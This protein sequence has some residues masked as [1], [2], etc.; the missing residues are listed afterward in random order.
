MCAFVEPAFERRAIDQ[1][2]VVS[3][4]QLAGDVV[5]IGQQIHGSKAQLRIDEQR[6][7]DGLHV[8]VFSQGQCRRHAR[9]GLVHLLAQRLQRGLGLVELV[10]DAQHPEVAVRV[11]LLRAAPHLVHLGDVAV[12]ADDARSPLGGGAAVPDARGVV[13]VQRQRHR[14]A[15]G[16]EIQL[17]GFVGRCHGV[18]SLLEKSGQL[19]QEAEG[20]QSTNRNPPIPGSGRGGRMRRELSPGDSSMERQGTL[21]ARLSP[22]KAAPAAGDR[23]PACSGSTCSRQ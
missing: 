19:R 6:Q 8:E 12:Q 22:D 11:V 16:A 15:Q 17:Q 18:R 3:E 7:L 21:H 2:G 1:R 5:V 20:S 13:R 10:F 14:A 23:S 9:Q 4:D